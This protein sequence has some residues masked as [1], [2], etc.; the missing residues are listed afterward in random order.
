ESTIHPPTAKLVQSTLRSAEETLAIQGRKQLLAPRGVQL[1]E[2]CVSH[3]R[4]IAKQH[5]APRTLVAAG[6]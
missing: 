3:L 2:T 5:T 4:D 6:A 1:V